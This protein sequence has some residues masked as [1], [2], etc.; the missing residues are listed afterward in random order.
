LLL[1]GTGT[2]GGV[3]EILCDCKVCRSRN[4]RDNRLRCSAYLTSGP[5]RLL[6]DASPDFRQQVRR[7]S[8]DRI[9]EILITHGHFDHIGGLDDIR[10]FNWKSGRIPLRAAPSTIGLLK[11]RYPYFDRPVQTG[12]GVPA[13]EW[14]AVE[15][16]F[17]ASGI[18]VV[19]LPV[20]HGIEP[21]L[22]YRF[23]DLAYLTD[24][25]EVPAS[26]R[27]LMRDLDALV[28]GAIRFEPHP[29]H[30]N[31][32]QALDFISE[33]RPRRTWLTHITHKFGHSAVDRSL[34]K[35]VHLAW[36]GLKVKVRD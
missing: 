9:D 15:G 20:K 11:A 19:P 6:I 31:L 27:G 24:V 23:G 3:P 10:P 17:T 22:G 28:L 21:V 2:S 36:D 34:P 8:V 26:T 7:A 5:A 18:R 32:E 12:G 14:K 29:T 25:S 30:F 4:P 35:G 1:L 16:P 13:V 33:I